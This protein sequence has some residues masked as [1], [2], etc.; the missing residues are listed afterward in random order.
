MKRCFNHHISDP[1]LPNL[2]GTLEAATTSSE[3]T[4]R[5]VQGAVLME[6]LLPDP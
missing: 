1:L 4:A 5:D 3:Q 6:H 2:R